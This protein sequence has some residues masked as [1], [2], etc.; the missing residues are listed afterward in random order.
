MNNYWYDQKKGHLCTDEGL[1]RPF[2]CAVEATPLTFNSTE[3][4]FSYL[5]EQHIDGKIITVLQHGNIH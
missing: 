5:K 3:E 1:T 4:C 2:I